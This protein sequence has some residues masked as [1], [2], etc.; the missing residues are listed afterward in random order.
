M[1]ES[2]S[3]ATKTAETKSRKN[4]SVTDMPP[5]T[6]GIS[7]TSFPSTTS[8]RQLKKKVQTGKKITIEIFNFN[9]NTKKEIVI[10]LRKTFKC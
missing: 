7:P 5:V 9:G 8:S 4:P 6:Q 10:N 1:S 2:V 3:D